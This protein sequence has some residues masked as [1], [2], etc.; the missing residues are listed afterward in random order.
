LEIAHWCPQIRW[1]GVSFFRLYIS[2]LVAEIV[3]KGGSSFGI[4]KYG[5]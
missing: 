1:F 4:A 3:S 5:W 2:G